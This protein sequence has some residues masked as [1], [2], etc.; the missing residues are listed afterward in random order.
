[1]ADRCL[2]VVKESIDDLTDEEI[3]ELLDILRSRQE[4]RIARG[5][6]ENLERD[7]FNDADEL[8]QDA[9]EAAQIEKR[10]RLLNIQARSNLMRLVDEADRAMDD[11]S[12]GLQAA[13]VGSTRVFRGSSRSA[14]A[15]SAALFNEFGGGM[16][17]DLRRENLLLDF[18][19]RDIE[20]DI[21]RE[22]AE[23]TK[24]DSQPGLTGNENARKIAA[25]ID[26]YRKSMIG[27]KNRAGAWIKPLPGYVIRQSHDMHKLRRAGFEAWRDTVLPRLDPERTFGDADPE[28]FLREAYNALK[29]GI[30][31]KAGEAE[32]DLKLAFKGPGNLAKRLSQHR[33]LH[34]KDADSFMEYNQ[35]FGTRGLK[36]AIVKEM[37]LSAR[38]IALMET[39][40][41]N[42]R[43]M[44]DSVMG[45]LKKRYRN[46]DKKLAR[47]N[48][49]TLEWQFQ[50]ID[51]TSRMPGNTDWASV[52][53]TVRGVQNWSKLGGATLSAM[54]DV[55]FHSGELHRQGVPLMR[56][57]SQALQ[58]LGEGFS[59]K[60]QRLLYDLIGVGLDGQLGDLAAR[61]SP[62]DTVPG[63]VAKTNQIFFKYSLL[64]PWTDANKRGIGAM[65]ARNLA[66]EKKKSFAQ[67]PD[68]W[69]RLF[70]RYGIDEE[71]WDIVRRAVRR[72]SDIDAS[73]T[74]TREYLMPSDI[75][76]LPDSVFGKRTKRQ[77]QRLKD[78]LETSLRS[79]YV[80]R[81]E[82]AAPTPGA[83]ETA[84]LQM[85]TQPGTVTGEA[86][87]F[88][89]Q[90]KSFATTVLTR[91]F[92]ESLFSGGARTFR[93][94]L[95]E[96]KG[97]M[98]GLANLIVGSTVMGYLAMSAKDLAKGRTPRDIEDFQTWTAAF[99]Q[100]GGGGIYGDFLFGE[101][102][103]FGRSL[104]GTLAGPTFGTVDDIDRIRAKILAGEDVDADVLRLAMGNTPFLN[105]FYTR[106]A[107]DYLILYQLQEAVSPGYLR[108]MERNLKRENDQEFVIPPSR[109]IPRGGGTRLGEGVR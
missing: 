3:G 102:N 92:G 64:A 6:I 36:E 75:K 12:L 30:H 2:A 42:P 49:L 107:L 25:V 109:R 71:G 103:R 67:M 37:E 73:I 18:N 15:R 1:M 10:N 70:R 22:L 91:N 89:A 74:D 56:S 17:A 52:A 48:R 94:A 86:V 45:D 35:R 38:Q 51:G 66:V 41:P 69:Q 80:D 33:V 106:V 68:H 58:N 47:L 34:F 98:M 27:R 31:M 55:V 61:F 72:G 88:M 16:V 84:I 5:Q 53:S 87:R 29:S 21:A 81:G 99:V 76:E 59:K 20:L 65:M 54:A 4:V 95:L 24:A 7:L 60:D 100:G 79:L 108:R 28:T 9:V 78:D 8:A 90:F 26:K 46:D 39:F 105:M 44:F 85:G 11:P 57:W 104:L 13:M 14:D 82:F 62:T 101:T 77:I 40:G 93:E 96:G 50:Q 83:R 32:I 23:I 97:D 63:S 43:A 19:S